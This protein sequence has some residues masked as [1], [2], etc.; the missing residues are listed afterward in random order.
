M[1]EA[2]GEVVEDN[3]APDQLGSE[4]ETSGEGDTPKI[5]KGR[6]VGQAAVNTLRALLEAPTEATATL[7]AIAQPGPRHRDDR[8]L[9][10]AEAT[11][12]KSAVSRKSTMCAGRVEELL[13]ID[14]L[15]KQLRCQES[16]PVQV[17]SAARWAGAL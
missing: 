4:R 15:R 16:G 17:P 13:R 7:A 12:V 11:A 10:E 8:H 14:S 1:S 3:P 6:R 5:S 2:W 9:D